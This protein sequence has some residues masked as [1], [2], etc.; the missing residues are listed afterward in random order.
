MK[1]FKERNNLQISKQL[2]D[3]ISNILQA[4][5]RDNPRVCESKRIAYVFFKTIEICPAV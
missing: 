1:Y 4:F 2:V 3:L 5:A